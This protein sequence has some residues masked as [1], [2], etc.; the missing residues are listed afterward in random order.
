MDLTTLPTPLL[1]DAYLYPLLS[2]AYLY[3]LLTQITRPLLLRSEGVVRREMR[4]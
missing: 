2:D 1:S 3:H 4:V